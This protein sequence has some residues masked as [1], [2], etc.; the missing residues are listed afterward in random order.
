MV[1]VALAGDEI[2]I[3]LYKLIVHIRMQ[4]VG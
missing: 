3:D 1:S 4:D 2:R